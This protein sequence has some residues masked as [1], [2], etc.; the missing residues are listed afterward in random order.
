MLHNTNA[1]NQV[2]VS[3]LPEPLT[4]CGA[5]CG[6]AETALPIIGTDG[7]PNYLLTHVYGNVPPNIAAVVAHM[8]QCWRPGSL[9]IYNK[10]KNLHFYLN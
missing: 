2:N 10:K 8:H 9:G 5:D 7:I 3:H 6:D 4:G 1:H